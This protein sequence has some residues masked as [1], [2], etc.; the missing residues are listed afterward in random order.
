MQT[1]H[2]SPVSSNTLAG[3][4]KCAAGLYQGKGRGKETRKMKRGKEI[5]M[6][7]TKSIHDL[8]FNI[9]PSV[10]IWRKSHLKLFGVNPISDL[11]RS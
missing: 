6:N 5:C 1:D 11:S 3:K 8:F 10:R 4:S 7:K 2:T 9:S